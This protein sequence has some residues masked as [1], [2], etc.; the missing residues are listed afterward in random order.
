MALYIALCACSS[1]GKDQD[2]GRLEDAN[3]R[4]EEQAGQFNPG[5]QT[6][7][8]QQHIAIRVAYENGAFT[9]GLSYTRRPGRI[10]FSKSGGG[11]FVVQMKNAAGATIGT[12]YMQNPAR[13]RTCD[14]EPNT[15]GVRV[16]D[17]VA[18]DLLLPMDQAIAGVEFI[19]N[20]KSIGRISTPVGR[21]TDSTARDIPVDTLI[22]PR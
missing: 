8:A 13:Q 7:P 1:K 2:K 17:K 21:L 12:Y 20:G 3:D 15:P 4:M 6:N 10:P 22:R 16:L 11:D 18:F 14:G 19:S 5:F 9:P